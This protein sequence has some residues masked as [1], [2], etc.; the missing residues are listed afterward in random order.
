MTGKSDDHLRALMAEAHRHDVPPPFRETIARRRRFRPPFAA[1]ALLASSA[2][3]L[4][5]WNRPRSPAVAPA[6]EE[7]RIE[8]N[9]PL[10]FLLEPPNAAVIGSV[11]RFDDR[12]VLP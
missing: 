1:L 6:P 9:D 8:W 2:A 12:G 5:L 11:P 10:A 3:A 4:L 7:L